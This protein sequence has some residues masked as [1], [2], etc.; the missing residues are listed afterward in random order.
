MVHV[1]HAWISRYI[2]I[3]FSILFSI[4]FSSQDHILTFPQYN[5]VMADYDSLLTLKRNHHRN[6]HIFLL[7]HVNVV[8]NLHL[9]L[10]IIDSIR[11][12]I[13]T[14]YSS[15]FPTLVI[16]WSKSEEWLHHS[17]NTVAIVSYQNTSL[18][19]SIEFILTVVRNMTI[20]I[21]TKVL[22]IM[23]TCIYIAVVRSM[24]MCGITKALLIIVT[25]VGF[26]WQQ[27]GLWPCLLS[28]NYY[29]L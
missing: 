13:I 23:V 21:I 14:G 26:I 3:V 20:C 9:T 18:T 28:L 4:P 16:W 5:S 29:L 10:V 12:R 22:P 2:L 7:I 24:T 25:Y 6:Q 19:N 8:W 15:Q 1:S 17:N 11:L 27:S